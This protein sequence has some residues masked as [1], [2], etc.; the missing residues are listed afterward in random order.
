MASSSTLADHV[1][2]QVALDSRLIGASDSPTNFFIAAEQSS[3]SNYAREGNDLII[4]FADGRELRIAQFF[5]HGADYHNLVFVH[6]GSWLTSF[7]QALEASGDGILDPLVT[8]ESIDDS[9]AVVALLGILSGVVATALLASDGGG[10][11]GGHLVDSEAPGQ[12]TIDAV[13]DDVRPVT[14]PI[15]NGGVTDDT[16]PT[17]GGT[18]EPGSTITIYDNGRAIGSAL[19]GS[20]RH[21]TFTPDAPL[22]D[23]DHTFTVTATDPAGN[24]SAPSDPITVIVDTQAPDAPTIDAIDDVTHDDQPTLSGTG[25]PGSVITIHDGDEVIGS[26]TVDEDGTWTFTPDAPLTDG[27]HTFTV[28]ATDEAG[29]ESAPSDPITV[30]VDTQAPEAPT[31][32]AID[33]VTNDDQPTLSG[34]GEPGSVITIH[35]GDEVI[36]SVTVDEDGTW[37]FTPDTPL[38]DGDH[39]FTV[40][41]TDPAGNESAPSD[42]ITV[43]VDTQAPDAPTI[44]AIDDV[45]NDDQPTLS[46][47]GEPGSVIT[48]HDGDEVIGSVTVDEDGTWTFTPDAPLTDGDHTF[49]VTA[50]DPAG[51]E[52]APSDPTTVIVD[53]QAPDAPTIGGINDDV[54][55]VTGTVQDGD[56]TNDNQP[57][58]S[59]TGEPGSVITIH[60]GDE[61]IGS[62]T[63]GEDGTWSFTPDT[64][65]TDGDHTITVTATDPAGNESAPSDPITVTVDTQ[66]PDAPVIGGIDDDVAP[67]TG[68]VQDG[69]ATNDNQPTL[70]GT[71]E[72]GSTITIHDGDEV[73]GSVTVDEDGTWTFTPDT[74]LTDGDHTIT[75]TATD[76]AGN[77]GADSGPV[78]LTVDTQ[79]PTAAVTITAVNDDVDPAQGVVSNGG[80]T[81]DTA[82]AVSGTL[83]GALGAGEVVEVLRDGVVIGTATVTGTTWSIGDTGLEDGHTYTYTARVVDGAGN[84]GGISSD[85]VITVDTTA[86][87][88]TVRIDTIYDNVGAVQGVIANGGATDDSLPELR[89]SLSAALG[90]DEVVSIYRDGVKVGEATVSGTGWTYTDSGL[91]NGSTYSYTAV[92]EDAAGNAGAV[93]PAY[94]LTLQPTGPVQNVWITEITEDAAPVTGVVANGGHTNSTI[95]N[96]SGTLTAWLG[97]GEVVSIYRDGAF[98]GNA[99]VSGTNWTYT[100]PG[101]M[102]GEHAY[103]AVVENSLGDQGSVSNI[104]TITVDTVPPAQTV[105]ITEVLDNMDPAT[106]PIP[107]GGQ[108]DD[109]TPELHGMISAP[110]SGT[111]AVHVFRDGVDIGMATVSG[112]TWTFTDGSLSSGS[113]YTYTAQVVSA[114]GYTSVVSNSWTI[115]LNTSTGVQTTSILGVEDDRDP[116][117]GRV[118]NHGW[119]NDATPTVT[120]AL[121]A[122]LSSGE[123]VVVYRDGAKVGEA[124]MV[125]GTSW[126]FADS[127]VADGEHT[128][129]AQV[130]NPG[131]GA[132]GAMS[133]AYVINVDT[134]T[135]PQSVTISGYMDDQAP[136]TGTFGFNVPT[137]DTTP[138]LEGTISSALAGNE[139]VAIYRDGVRI[140]TASVS[141]TMWTYQDA[142]LGDGDYSYVAR[143]EDAAG[144]A[145]LQSMGVTLTV[146]TTAPV[147]TVTITAVNDDVDPAQ[148][149]VAN[150]GSTNDTAPAVSGTLSGALGAGE[151]VEVLRDGVVI[152]T[153]TVTGTTW[154]IGDTGLEDG[155]TYTYTA[156]VVDGAGNV[157]GISSDYVITVDTTAPSQ[158]VRIDTI[159][160]NVGAVQGVIANGGATDDSLPE[161]RGSLS[162]ALG[163][164]EVVSIYR[165]GVKVGEATV[166]GTGWTYTDS[167]LSNGSTYSYTAVVEDAAGNAGAV[168]PAYGLTL[169]T[170]GPDTVVTIAAINDDVDPVQGVVADGGQTND[171][172]PALSGT[173]SGALAGGE[174]VAVY[175]DGVKVGEATVSGTN[176][177]FTDTGVTDGEHAYTAV[178]ENG[179]GLQGAMSNIYTITVDTVSPPQTVAITEVVDNMAPATGPVANGGHT[180]DSTP[181]LH[182]TISAALSGT[183]EVH[184]FR[185]GVDIGTATVSGT[186]WTFT[187]GSLS[188]GGSYTYTAQVV[189]G[190]GNAGASSNSWQITLDT[191]GGVQEVSI[192]GVTDDQAPDTGLV[193]NHGWT[194][195]ATPTVTGSLFMALSGGEVVAVY[196]DGVVV[197]T[198]TVT[199][200]SWTFADSGVADGEHTYTAQVENPGTGALIC[201]SGE[202]VINVDGTAPTQTVSI[203]GYADDQVAGTGSF[204]FNVPTNDTTPLL[205]GTVSSALAGNEVVAIYRDGVKIGEASVSGTT[206]T[207]QDSGLADGDYAYTA[208]VEDSAGNVGADSGPVTLTVDTQ[209]PTAAVTITAV[210]DDVDPAQGVV[211]NGG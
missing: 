203:D 23:G 94:D 162:A 57:T 18:G 112:T 149:V 39:T 175:R 180:D 196:R 199:G 120:G 116:V 6:D 25:E 128:Y 74:P 75:V 41:A 123:K 45:T 154:S 204:G 122:A 136:V 66:A 111:E 210:N 121:F 144:N 7:D 135:P 181:E 33:D 52:S 187:D 19:V 151:V 202:Y 59:G 56:V 11:G 16:R 131:T 54:A 20:D 188:S 133:N 4:S 117:Q 165:D 194:N 34:T 92:V 40:T 141:G 31:I 81:N 5:E 35:D 207:F 22:T 160:D 179:T 208:R 156:R 36:G 88:Q 168:S 86:P 172:S 176:W 152:G 100:D 68:G 183:E 64:P 84:V 205:E 174:V 51:N 134:S 189:D 50:T 82:P 138:V 29:N 99:A 209:A 38:T 91:S 142:G 98:L 60:D 85:Y 79:A 17:L 58:L 127:G 13:E 153:A 71:G 191:S 87:S 10:S 118:A 76:E 102:D 67:V 95:L 140:G 161:L 93:S 200:T 104:Y 78:T 63:V 124:T 155:H 157:G 114:A 96:L 3:V 70:S 30:T 137:N 9:G 186:T 24:E 158:T 108:T 201:Q 14:G 147:Q 89:G 83:S 190:A 1:N 192:L 12:P 182:G 65:L 150:G 43:T 159:Y 197:G 72:P 169:Q 143:V 167:G 53:T 110:L 126:A 15:A 195:D 148:G 37:T 61:V 139:V 184:V 90:A 206:W 119:T 73:I 177:T 166:S 171:T 77:V 26:V 163:A 46:G 185:D 145:G 193:T 170:T 164:D 211:A 105:A 106:G 107:N 130:E 198:A 28:T 109:S 80:S 55:P 146:D 48:I 2:V 44:D 113:S 97:G 103:T 115:S 173:L 27:D 132:L 8:Y 47:T 42:P 101:A 125:T 129:T 62:V 178:V 49:T 21:W 69:A 32:D